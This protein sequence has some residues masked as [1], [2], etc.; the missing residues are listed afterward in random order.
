[1]YIL[2]C[3][4]VALKIMLLFTLGVILISSEDTFF[5]EIAYL[6]AQYI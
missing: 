2:Y 6:T 3:H 5:Y 1:M 4:T